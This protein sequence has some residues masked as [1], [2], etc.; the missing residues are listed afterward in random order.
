[1]TS[2]DKFFKG[3]IRRI[4]GEVSRDED[5][6][7]IYLCFKGGAKVEEEAQLR[8]LLDLQF[9]AGADLITVQQPYDLS[10]REF[11]SSLS[12]AEAWRRERGDE[13]PL[14]PVLKMDAPEEVL[15]GVKEL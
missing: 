12:Y 10:W 1:L 14:M 3:F 9:L 13:A 15:E 8:T 6:L 2:D 7:L 4:A 11:R 5:L